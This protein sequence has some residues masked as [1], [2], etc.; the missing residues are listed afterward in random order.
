MKSKNYYDSKYLSGQNSVAKDNIPT[1]L[2]IFRRHATEEMTVLDFGCGAGVLLSVINC[3]YKIGVDINESALAEAKK[4]GINEVHLSLNS[5]KQN[6]IDLIIS[7]SALEHVPNP[8]EV[9]SKLYNI[10]KPNG[11]IV[12]R[13]P[14]ETLGWSYKPGDWNYHLYTW[15]PMAIGNLIN[16]VGFTEI[17][18]SIERSKRPPFFKLLRLIRSERLGGYFYRLFRLLLDELGIY[19]IAVDGYCIVEAVKK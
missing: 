13:V 4:I 7:N 11:K 3:K 6:S 5:L 17:K 8:H 10:L 1:Y 2:R 12:F 18:V 9:L 16:D 15:S 19:S 14:H